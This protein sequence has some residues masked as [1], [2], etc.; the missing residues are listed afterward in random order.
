[1]GLTGVGLTSAGLTR[2]RRCRCAVKNISLG[3]ALRAWRLEFQSIFGKA[4]GILWAYGWLLTIWTSV[5]YTIAT[6]N[7][8]CTI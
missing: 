2:L 1:M 3:G 7:S 5:D 6:R 8:Q 4:S